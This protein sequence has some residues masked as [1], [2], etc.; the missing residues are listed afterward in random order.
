MDVDGEAGVVSEL[1]RG[2]A[3]RC[4]RRAT[5]GV[6]RVALWSAGAVVCA[7]AAAGAQTR[8]PG[9]AP[10][11]AVTA[12]RSDSVVSARGDSVSIRL[13]DVDLRV[14]VQALGRYLDRP[15]LLGAAPPSR[16]TLETPH[17]VPRSDAL[18]LLRGLVESQGLELVAEPDA[19]MY[20]VRVKEPPKPTPVE[21]VGPRPPAAGLVEL[22]VIHLRHARAADVAASVN[23]LYGRASALGELGSDR[24]GGSPTLADGLRQNVVPPELIGPPSAAA[25]PGVGGRNAA[26]AGETTIIPDPRT[27]SLLIRAQRADFDLISAAVKELDVRPLQVLIQV[28]IAEVSRSRSLSFGLEFGVP[29]SVVPRTGGAAV[30]SA[31]QSGLGAGD[32]VLNVLRH[33]AG[34]DWDATLAAAAARGDARIISRPV[35]IAANNEEAEILVGS[36]RPFV[37]VSRSLPTESAQRDQ[38]I[39]YKDVGTR[40][41]V[42]PTISDDGYVSLQLTQEVNNATSEQ[43]FN[44]P[45]IS[46][47]TVRTQLLV[48]DSQTVVLGG[49]SDHQHEVEQSGVPVLSSIPFVGGLFGRATRQTSETEFYLFITPRIIRTDEDAGALTGAFQSRTP[50]DASPKR[51]AIPDSTPPGP[52]SSTKRPSP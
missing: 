27:N 44:A 20:R 16:V 18:R 40:L 17:A 50:N 9:A 29:T 34:M 48:R 51:A 10:S 33:G 37:Q 49:L 32:F 8:T 45:V 43:Q 25:V 38:V 7:A 31:T 12:A 41:N 6:H 21:F 24:R 28:L 15:V 19:A 52:P 5:R 26:F 11:G 13:V 46:T 4:V 3:W 23:A 42:R 39:Q 2:A 47:R 14:A 35:V 22:F 1:A 36:Q 30:A